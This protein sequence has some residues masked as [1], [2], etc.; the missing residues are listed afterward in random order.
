MRRKRPFVQLQISP[1]GSMGDILNFD[2]TWHSG[3]AYIRNIK[4]RLPNDV[5]TP[6][7]MQVRYV[8]R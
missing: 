8:R 7:E 5:K 3:A 4:D 1:C 2:Y 6:T